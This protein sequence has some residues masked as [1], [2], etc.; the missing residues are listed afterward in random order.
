MFNSTLIENTKIEQLAIKYLHTKERNSYKKRKKNS[1]KK[2]FL[3]SR[4]IIKAIVENT[5]HHNFKNLHLSFDHEFN[6]LR[7][8]LNDVLLPLSLSISHSNGMV[9][10]A[11]CD[12]PIKLGVD[13][14]NMHSDR[15]YKKLSLHFFNNEDNKIVAIDGKNAFYRIW[16][17]KESFCKLTNQSILTSLKQPLKNQLSSLYAFSCQYNYYDISVLSD[18][19]LLIKKIYY[20][21]INELTEI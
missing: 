13:L 16:T 21:N 11:L 7:L 9:F 2:E 8:F 14:E 17:L 3:A 18:V 20:L 10:V 15:D 1:A 5:Y 12:E 6:V 4:F 19:S